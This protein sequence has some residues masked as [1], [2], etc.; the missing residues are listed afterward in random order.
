M[1]L[2]RLKSLRLAR[3]YSLRELAAKSKIPYSAISLLENL[4]REPQG[5]TARNLAAALEVTPTDLCE[6]VP[7]PP[8]QPPAS[9]DNKVITPPTTRPRKRPAGISH[10]VIENSPDPDQVEPFRLDTR[11]EAERLAAR[12]GPGQARIYE[13]ESKTQVWQLHRNFLVRVNRGQEF[14]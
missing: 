12:L 9:N 4:K 3:G 8:P 6:Q 7:S 14:W 2:T 13:A 10:W 11:E 5:R 1:L